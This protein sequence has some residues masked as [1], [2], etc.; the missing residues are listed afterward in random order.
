MVRPDFGNSLL[1]TP[2]VQHF[3]NLSYLWQNGQVSQ[4]Q[5]I[6]QAGLYSVTVTSNGCRAADTV[7]L[8]TLPPPTISITGKTSICKEGGTD[9]VVKGGMA[10]SGSP[11]TGLSNPQSA[12]PYAS[13]AQTTKNFFTAFHQNGCTALDSVTITVTPKTVFTAISSNAVLC[14]G[15]TAILSAAE[16]TNIPGRLPVH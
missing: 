3:G 16:V 6:Q 12:N 13:P 9:L 5:T 14:K 8:T 1:N 2:T 7:S 11:T 10:Y 4:K 15:D